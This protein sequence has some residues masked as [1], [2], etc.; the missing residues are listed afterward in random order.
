[1]PAASTAT[2]FSVKMCLP[3]AT[4]GGEVRGPEARRRREDHEVDVG[5]EHL[6]VRVEAGEARVV[7]DLVLAPRTPASALRDLRELGA[8]LR[9]AIGHEVAHRDELDALRAAQAVARRAGAA[10]AAAD[11]RR[12]GSR[13]S[14][15]TR[16]AAVE[17]RTPR[18]ARGGGLDERAA[19]NGVRCMIGPC[20]CVSR[21]VTHD[22]S[23]DPKA[24]E[25]SIGEPPAALGQLRIALVPGSSCTARAAGSDRC[26]PHRGTNRRAS[27]ARH[28]AS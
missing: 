22:L 12:R 20:H 24:D 28:R 3:A 7:G 16:S 26:R 18:S 10:A 4:R 2:G 8:A 23:H 25:R 17:A 9:E 6:L 14:R 15:A 5:R 1:M 11:R 27:R 21:L 13:R 19:R